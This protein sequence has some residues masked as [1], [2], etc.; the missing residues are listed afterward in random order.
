MAES[1]RTAGGTTTTEQRYFATSLPAGAGT[2][3]RC[4]R[5]HWGVANGLHWTLDVAFREDESRTR[6]DHAAAN[7]AVA[8]R[9]GATLRKAETTPKGGVQTKRMRCAWN[10]DYYGLVLGVGDA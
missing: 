10:G 8:R 3:A 7:L 5:G 4:V 2:L 9:V 6:T 1:T